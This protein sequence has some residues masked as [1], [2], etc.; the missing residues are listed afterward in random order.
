MAADDGVRWAPSD[1]PCPTG[2]PE[3]HYL[4]EFPMTCRRCHEWQDA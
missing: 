3:A 2:H 1:Q 4:G